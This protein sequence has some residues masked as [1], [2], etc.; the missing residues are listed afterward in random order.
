MFDPSQST[1]DRGDHEEQNTVL[2]ASVR[3]MDCSIDHELY[4]YVYRWAT[5][6]IPLMSLTGPRGHFID[7][8]L[9]RGI[10]YAYVKMGEGQV[11]K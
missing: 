8:L 7:G 4:Y 6:H 10:H 11:R 1:A 3:F 9:L 2:A 5:V